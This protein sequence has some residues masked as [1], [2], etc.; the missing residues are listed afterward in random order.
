MQKIPF[1]GDLA[2]KGYFLRFIIVLSNLV[3]RTGLEP[4][5]ISE[6]AAS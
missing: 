5:L 4:M 3:I 2:F 6:K 1:K